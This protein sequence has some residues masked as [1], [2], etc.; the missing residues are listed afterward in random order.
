VAQMRFHRMSKYPYPKTE[1]FPD[2]NGALSYQLDWND[3]FDSGAPVRSY[4]FDYRDMVSTPLEDGSV[5]PG[6]GRP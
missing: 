5:T 1:S 6:A 4:R 2:D 3:R